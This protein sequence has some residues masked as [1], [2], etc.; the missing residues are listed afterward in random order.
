M[1]FFVAIS[2]AF[3]GLFL[4]SAWA[5]TSVVFNE[6]MFHPATNE[7]V[8]EWFELFNQM[9][10]DVDISNWWVDGDIYYKFGTNV[11]LKGGAFLVVA[12]SP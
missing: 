12:I 11:V 9:A 8:M 10:V 1:R 2:F 5:D 7:P 4:G 3:L 6:I